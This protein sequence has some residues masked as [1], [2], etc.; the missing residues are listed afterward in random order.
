MGDLKN[1]I[2]QLFA[3]SH[4]QVDTINL[5]YENTNDIFEVSSDVRKFIR[6]DCAGLY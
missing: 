4:V 6:V 5:G 1:N 3:S 2:K